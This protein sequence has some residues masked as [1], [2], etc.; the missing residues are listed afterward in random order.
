MESL[1]KLIRIS[2]EKFAC[3][4]SGLYSG[5]RYDRSIILQFCFAF[6]TVVFFLF[7][8]ITWIEW[9]FVITAIFTVLIAEY[10]NSAIEDTCDLLVDRY[11]LQVKE[12][13]DIAAAAVLLAA[14]YAV[15]VASTII[16]RRF[17]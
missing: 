14:I 7:Y 9:L 15:I 8:K 10:I 11:D 13:K 2:I 1:K 12:I 16:L 3:A 4:F 17:L 5:I 6:I